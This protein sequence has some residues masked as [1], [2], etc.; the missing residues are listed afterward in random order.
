MK[1]KT[2]ACPSAE[3]VSVM[4]AGHGLERALRGGGVAFKGLLVPLGVKEK[5]GL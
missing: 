2:A 4:T 5:P 1:L 3:H